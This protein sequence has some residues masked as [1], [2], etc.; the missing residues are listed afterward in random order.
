MNI[1]TVTSDAKQKAKKTFFFIKK[2]VFLKNSLKK[3][4]LQCVFILYTVSS[5][6][7]SINLQGTGCKK[8]ACM[9][10]CV[11]CIHIG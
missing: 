7:Y 9:M 1:Y 4:I 10:H 6:I 3:N 11:N 2:K 5:V 8:I